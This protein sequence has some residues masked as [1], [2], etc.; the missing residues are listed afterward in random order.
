M[1]WTNKQLIS[2]AMERMATGD[3]KA[4]GALMHP[5]FVW[6][7]TGT[8]SWSGEYR[9]RDAV[10]K[11]LFAPLFANFTSTYVNRPVNIIAEGDVV[12]VECRAHAMTKSA[13]RTIRPIAM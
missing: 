9:G 11:D 5:N 7:A 13:S 3:T 12:V 8:N 10:R 4:I 2:D 6:T 1:T